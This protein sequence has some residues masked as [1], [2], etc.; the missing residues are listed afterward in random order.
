MPIAW[1]VIHGA[2]GW[3]ASTSVGGYIAGTL[4]TTWAGAFVLGNQ[5]LITA[6]GAF[7]T[8]AASAAAWFG[9]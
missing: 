9:L 8:G 1:P 4:S 6:T 3:I 7:A 5:L 2:G